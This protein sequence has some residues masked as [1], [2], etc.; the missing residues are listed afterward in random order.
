MSLKYNQINLKINNSNILADSVNVSESSPQK[1]IY[2]FNNNVPYDNTPSNIK[3]NIS[4]SYFLEPQNEPNYHI[5]S[6]LLND[7]TSITPSIINIGD[8]YITG[9]LS[10]FSLKLAPNSLIKVSSDFEIYYPFTGIFVAQSS[11]DWNLYNTSNSSGLSHYWSAQFFSGNSV[12]SNNNILQLDY[13][14]SIN[15]T[16]IYGIGDPY[17][18][19][20]YIQNIEENVNILSEQ[21]INPS[22]SGQKIED[23][24]SSLQ[25]L[26]INNISS[27]WDNSINYNINIPLTGFLL[28]E[29]KSSLQIDNL[30]FFE[31]NFSRYH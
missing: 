4:I 3:G 10:N 25:Q 28:K 17:P 24:L 21:Q 9:Y 18:K 2:S 14:T 20:V 6:G 5:L 15:L 7:S 16:P 8:I 11:G 12:I 23:I 31:M 30:I 13:Q 27:Q 29:S 22:F 26:K 19:Q 1:P